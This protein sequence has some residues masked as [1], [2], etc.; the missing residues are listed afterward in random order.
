MFKTLY[1]CPRTV[2]RHEN[3]PLQES[4]RRDLE[5]LAA[6]GAALHTLQRPSWL[7]PQDTGQASLLLMRLGPNVS[8]K[9]GPNQVVKTKGVSRYRSGET[10][11]SGNDTFHT[12]LS[13]ICSCV[14][15][16]RTTAPDRLD[17][18]RDAGANSEATI[19]ST[20]CIRSERVIRLAALGRFAGIQAA[21]GHI[22][23]EGSNIRLLLVDR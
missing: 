19:P 20:Q 21:S 15:A 4:R 14:Q 23:E 18:A 11:A 8:V 10:P 22:Y 6:Q 5:H 13:I 7:E 12:P 2:A 17:T 3:G 9:V 1:R 16:R